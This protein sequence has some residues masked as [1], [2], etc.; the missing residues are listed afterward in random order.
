M[1]ELLTYAQLS[2][3]IYDRAR[4]NRMDVPEAESWRELVW[5]DDNPFTG[6]SAGAYRKGNKVVIA[7][8]GANEAMLGDFLVVASHPLPQ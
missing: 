3:R 8:T 2:G 5:L 1:A 7:F 4:A 6:F